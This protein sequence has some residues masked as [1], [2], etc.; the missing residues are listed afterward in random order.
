MALLK[1]NIFHGKRGVHM[2][3]T[4]MRAKTLIVIGREHELFGG[5]IK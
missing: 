5:N 2:G 3:I 1:I 4:R